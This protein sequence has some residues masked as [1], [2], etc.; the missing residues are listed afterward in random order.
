MNITKGVIS[1]DE[2]YRLAPDYVDF[3]ESHSVSMQILD[4]FNDT[5]KRGRQFLT[6]V[7]NY[8]DATMNV[9]VVGKISSSKYSYLNEDGPVV[10]FSNGEYIWRIDGDGFGVAL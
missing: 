9:Y 5:A 7:R 4:A 10:R 1:R 3:I 2:A 8:Q 6:C